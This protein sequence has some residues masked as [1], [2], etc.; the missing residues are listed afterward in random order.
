MSTSELRTQIIKMIT[1]EKE[2]LA[3]YKN[4]CAKFQITPNPIPEAVVQ[5]RVQTM[6]M[7]LKN[8]PTSNRQIE[9]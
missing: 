1:E 5:A 6:E 9:K 8:L 2:S 7:V 4:L 3:F